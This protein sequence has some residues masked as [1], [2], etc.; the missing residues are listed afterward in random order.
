MAIILISP[1]SGQGI[2]L[3][4]KSLTDQ[5]GFDYKTLLTPQNMALGRAE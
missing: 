2:L 4:C 1:Q 5:T 3:R